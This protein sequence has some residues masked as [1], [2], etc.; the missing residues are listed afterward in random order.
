M[1]NSYKFLGVFV[2]AATLLGSTMALAASPKEHSIVGQV[3]KIDTVANT[4]TVM[5]TVGK[6]EKQVVFHLAP[7]ISI[8]RNNQ[9]VMLGDLREGDRVTVRYADEKGKL[10]AHAIALK[11]T[12]GESAKPNK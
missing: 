5:E 7:G 12:G 6:K 10:M 8:T 4:V 9:T 1:Q 11:N 2:M 3:K